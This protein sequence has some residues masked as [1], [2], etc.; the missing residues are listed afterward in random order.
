MIR[1]FFIKADQSEEPW[2]LQDVFKQFSKKL[3]ERS[4]ERIILG[5]VSARENW[6]KTK[7]SG[8]PDEIFGNIDQ[9]SRKK[10][11]TKFQH[12]IFLSLLRFVTAR[13]YFAHHSFKDG[14]LNYHVEKLTEQILTSCLESVIYMDFVVQEIVSKYQTEKK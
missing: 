10:K 7:L 14:T 13:N 3:S 5:E 1:T 4:K 11:W 12:H 9:I 6:N 8:K 2:K